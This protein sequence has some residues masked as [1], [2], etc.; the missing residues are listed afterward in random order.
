[1]M[2]STYLVGLGLVGSLA[3][4]RGASQAAPLPPSLPKMSALL[5]KVEKTPCV[6]NDGGP[7]EGHVGLM[8]AGHSASLDQV[9]FAPSCNVY[10]WSGTTGEVSSS[11]PLCFPFILLP[12]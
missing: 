4:L 9:W 6:C 2:K 7:N 1:M 3:L 11:G 8:S 10:T 12:K 5:A